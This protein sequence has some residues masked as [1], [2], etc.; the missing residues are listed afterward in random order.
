M[1]TN[2]RAVSRCVH[3]TCDAVSLSGVCIRSNNLTTATTT[4]SARA[5]NVRDVTL[6]SAPSARVAG[7]ERSKSSAAYYRSGFCL[8]WRMATAAYRG[9]VVYISRVVNFKGLGDPRGLSGSTLQLLYCS[10]KFTTLSGHYAEDSSIDPLDCGDR[11]YFICS[12]FS[13]SYH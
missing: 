4:T 11:F 6:R 1:T 7:L 13:Q 8:C 5:R 12:F 3:D 10:P 9:G 2:P